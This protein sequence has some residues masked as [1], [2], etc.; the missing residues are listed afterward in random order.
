M[1]CIWWVPYIEPNIGRYGV[2]KSQVRVL[3]ASSRAIQGMIC[4]LS[5]KEATGL[6]RGVSDKGE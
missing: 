6:P 3:E 4:S 5:A 2:H 1:N